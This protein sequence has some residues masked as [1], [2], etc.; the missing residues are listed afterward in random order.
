MDILKEQAS[1]LPSL[2]GCY[3][4]RNR[5]DT[6]IYIGKSKCLKNRVK[7]YFTGLDSQKG[8][9]KCLVN[10]IYR[11]E[12]VITKTELDAILL[13]C[14]LI[15]QFKP[16]FNTLLKGDP[17]F[18][19]IKIGMDDSYPAISITKDKGE[20]LNHCFGFFYSDR[21]A[22]E[23]VLLMNSIWKTPICNK[24]SFI[25]TDRT[26]L[27][28]HLG[29]CIG[30]CSEKIAKEEYHEILLEMMKCLNG[31][32]QNVIN[33]YKKEMHRFAEQME[34]ERAATMRNKIKSLYN[35][36]K[37]SHRFHIDFDTQNLY[38][39]LR[40][41]YQHSITII[42][43]SDHKAV[44]RIDFAQLHRIEEDI[45]TKFVEEIN[46]QQYNL[47]DSKLNEKY[48][49]NA[50]Y[51][52]YE[53]N[54]GYPE[55]ETNAEHPEHEANA[56]HPKHEANEGY[57]QYT[58]NILGNI[59]EIYCDKHFLPIKSKVNTNYMVKRI[60]KELLYLE[61]KPFEHIG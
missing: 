46:N 40:P 4:Y 29:K 14:S 51:S 41:F 53:A 50:G 24:R 60:M 39:F 57:L 26:C 21:E 31:K 22:L 58:G 11:I 56:E 38:V 44:H 35:L 52:K 7:Q 54:E 3:I 8:K 32:T 55:H 59:L 30:P 28:Y 15:K 37:K 1:Q 20:G 12:Y 47:S 2:P 10:E 48:I 13:E 5:L 18:T 27:S 43:I 45:L 25:D 19:Y 61:E 9:R 6:I 49:K 17:R 33:R 34:F 36:T 23:T 16:K 42:Y